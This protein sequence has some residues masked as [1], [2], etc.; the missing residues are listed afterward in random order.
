M[1]I[2]LSELK[3]QRVFRE[4]ISRPDDIDW[5]GICKCIPLMRYVIK[6]GK[7]IIEIPCDYR[8]FNLRRLCIRESN[9]SFINYTEKKLEDI[10]NSGKIVKLDFKVRFYSYD[11]KVL[12]FIILN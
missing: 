9:N 11:S 8:F 10:I 4:F 6:N 12:E 1:N 7:E 2:C 3:F 5:R